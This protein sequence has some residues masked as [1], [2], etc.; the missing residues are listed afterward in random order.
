M[1]LQGKVALVTGAA[2]GIGLEYVKVMLEN[3]LKHAAVLDVNQTAGT[4]AVKKL[5][6]KFRADAA[7]FIHCDVTNKEHL[8]AA[9]TQT[10]RVF[11]R[12]HVVVNNA[13]L[14]RGCAWELEISVNLT[15]LVRSTLLALDLM[16]KD[17]GGEGGVVVN[18]ASVAGLSS[19]API[20][21]YSATKSAVIGFS[22]SLGAP[23][24]EAR[25]GV[26]V[27]TLCPGV[28]HTSLVT[29]SHLYVMDENWKQELKKFFT[30]FPSQT[31]ECVATAMLHI[32]KNAKSGSV[33]VI[34]GGKPVYEIE[35]PNY[36]SLKVGKKN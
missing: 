3:G 10:L 28:T 2:I 16:G 30:D 20:P 11:G 19:V 33:W 5:N 6:E 36:E 32:L 12:I 26:R 17:K 14:L 25:T 35:L 24:H 22:Q 27:L 4:A 9:F 7:I 23:F 13:G 8:E 15:A 34:E 31:P 29:D 21:V 1:D 18:I